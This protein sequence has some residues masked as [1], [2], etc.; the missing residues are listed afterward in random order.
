VRPTAIFFTDAAYCTACHY[1]LP[2]IKANPSRRFQ[3]KG[4]ILVSLLFSL[5][6]YAN[7]QQLKQPADIR[8]LTDGVMQKVLV[9]DFAAGF[10]MLKQNSNLSAAD[11]DGV[12][13]TTESQ[14]PKIETNYGKFIGVEF[15]AQKQ[16]GNSLLN[17]IYL[18][19]CEKYGLRW[20]F[21]FYNAGAGWNLINIDFDD[22]L[23]ELFT[24]GVSN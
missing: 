7:A 16:I 19:K 20:T 1:A 9:Q 15:L 3:M 10:G 17:M 13:A 5:A 6:S 4:L 23:Q 14:L 21:S 12:E 2:C 22:K 8:K 11:I 18:L 24:S